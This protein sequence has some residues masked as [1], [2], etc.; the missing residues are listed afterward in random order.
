MKYLLLVLV[1][2]G[3]AY[4]DSFP[5]SGP[6][7]DIEAC[8]KACTAKQ[9]GACYYGGALVSQRPFGDTG[10]AQAQSFFDRGCAQRDREACLMSARLVESGEY[11]AIKKAGPQT[12]AAYKRVCAMKNARAC[13]SYAQFLAEQ[14]DAKSKKLAVRV[15][16][17]AMQLLEQRCTQMAGACFQAAARYSYGMGV[18][19]DE[20]KS[21]DMMRRGCKLSP[22]DHRCGEAL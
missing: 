8:E 18:A 20:T 5:T 22:T 9:A 10:R 11:L 19:E 12:L 16:K 17:Q 6:C 13:F 7:D 1:M 2:T 4:A 14:S 21:Q 3:A 15:N